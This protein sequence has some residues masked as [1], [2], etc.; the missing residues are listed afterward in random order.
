MRLKALNVNFNKVET[1]SKLQRFI[2]RLFKIETMNY[3]HV[4]LHFTCDEKLESHDVIV[5]PDGT[6]Y[7]VIA[8]DVNMIYYAE[9]VDKLKYKPYLDGE[10]Y[11]GFRT[12]SEKSQLRR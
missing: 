1:L 3:Y 9:S 8:L 10:F 6:S 11:L 12:F 5:G 2:A 7:F 4:S